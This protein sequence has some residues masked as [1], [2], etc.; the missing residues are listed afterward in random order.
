MSAEGV[1]YNVWGHATSWIVEGRIGGSVFWLS[2]WY[3]NKEDAERKAKTM[4]AR[5]E[6][7]ADQP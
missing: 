6:L 7:Q 5:L 3:A 2:R 4:R 1:T